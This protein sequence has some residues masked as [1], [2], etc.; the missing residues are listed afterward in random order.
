MIFICD[1]DELVMENGTFS[2]II[3]WTTKDELATLDRTFFEG[4]QV[5]PVNKEAYPGY[6]HSEV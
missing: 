1:F 6:L 5:W 2:A 4:V 3:G